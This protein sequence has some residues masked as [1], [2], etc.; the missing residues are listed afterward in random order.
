M[1]V[2]PH[3]PY[4]PDIAPCDFALFPKMKLRLK[5]RRFSSLEEI[6]KETDVVLRSFGPA[7]FKDI[8]QEWKRR[9]DRC[10]SFGGEYFEGDSCNLF[11]DS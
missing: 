2:V 10:V 6:Q 4:S 11:E 9:W 8:F 5:G 1:T 7:F 3:P